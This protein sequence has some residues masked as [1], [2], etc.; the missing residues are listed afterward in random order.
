MTD[1]N[2]AHRRFS[3]RLRVFNETSNLDRDPYCIASSSFYLFIFVVSQFCWFR[4][5]WFGAVVQQQNV[6]VR[7]FLDTFYGPC[8][9]TKSINIKMQI[10]YINEESFCSMSIIDLTKKLQIFWPCRGFVL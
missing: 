3:V 6:R 9:L 4:L 10:V 1:S 5:A 8:I 2:N 7:F